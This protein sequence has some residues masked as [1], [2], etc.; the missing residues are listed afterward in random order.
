MAKAD[1]YIIK[2]DVTISDGKITHKFTED[3]IIH[4]ELEE[5][6]HEGKFSIKWIEHKIRNF[7]QCHT[8]GCFKKQATGFVLC[9]EC[10]IWD[11]GVA[12]D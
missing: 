2:A 7:N 8:Q 12:F 10:L 9:D 1:K 6:R 5:P 11:K 3:D 4:I